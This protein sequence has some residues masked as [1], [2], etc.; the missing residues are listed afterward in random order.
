MTEHA[1]SGWLT[2]G[3][4]DILFDVCCP[5]TLHPSDQPAM[6]VWGHFVV[7]PEVKSEGGL[8]WWQGQIGYRLNPLGGWDVTNLNGAKSSWGLD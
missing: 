8:K 4:L 7:F 5:D 2:T 6:Y 1:G 3:S